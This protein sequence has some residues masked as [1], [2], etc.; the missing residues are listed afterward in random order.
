MESHLRRG[1]ALA[2][3]KE[4][5]RTE[6]GSTLWKLVSLDSKLDESRSLSAQQ[7]DVTVANAMT[8][9]VDY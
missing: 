8:W 4:P 3:S 6:R 5:V 9:Q 7:S 2:R 1:R